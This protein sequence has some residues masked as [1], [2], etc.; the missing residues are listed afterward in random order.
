MSPAHLTA[1]ARLLEDPDMTVHSKSG[2]AIE[3]IS[4]LVDAAR[5]EGYAAGRSAQMEVTRSELETPIAVKLH[6]ALC[7]SC[8]AFP[9][10]D[11]CEP[12]MCDCLC[13]HTDM[14]FDEFIDSVCATLKMN[15]GPNGGV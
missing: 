7:G 1:I 9:G 11:A 5:D 2:T 12:S 8:P 3:R 10:G 4:A 15:R 14:D 6:T 13:P